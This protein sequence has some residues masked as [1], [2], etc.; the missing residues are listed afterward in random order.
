[1]KI[2]N[3]EQLNQQD[4]EQAGSDSGLSRRK[5][6][7]MIGAA[8]AAAAAG[9]LLS[10]TVG[11]AQGN[12]VTNSVYGPPL[13]LGPEWC[14]RKT[15]IAE[16]RAMTATVAEGIYYV[17]DSGK[18]G[19]FH[20]DASDTSSADNTGT[21]LVSASGLRFKR[22]YNGA[23]DALWFGAKGDGSTDDTAAIRLAIAAMQNGDSL[24]FPAGEYIVDSGCL[25]FRGLSNITI[26]G[27]GVNSWLHPSGQRTPTSKTSFHT[28]MAIDQCVSLTIRDLRIESKGENWG[29]TDAGTGAGWGDGRTNF[30]IEKG[31]HAL[32]VTRSGNVVVENIVGRLCG[33]V[34]VFY[35]SSCDD[36]VVRDC[37][38]NAS[39]LGYAMYAVDNW[40][41]PAQQMRR[42]YNF[43]NCNGWNEPGYSPYS[44]KA[45]ILVE[46]DPGMILN[47]NVQGG[48]FKNCTIGGDYKILGCAVGAV[49]ANANVNGVTSDSCLIGYLAGARGTNAENM[50]HTV[51]GCSFM[52]NR[53]T[54]VMLDFKAGTGDS[55][56]YLKDTVIRTKE[57]S[58]WSGYNDLR[59]KY[60]SGI[61]NL[62][63]LKGTVHLS[64]VSMAGGEYGM[65]MMDYLDLN[66]QSSEVSGSKSALTVYGGGN[67]ELYGTNVSSDL[68]H[69]LVFRTANITQ[70]GTSMA[71]R[72]LRMAAAYG[73]LNCGVDQNLF[74]IIG[75]AGHT[76]SVVVK[77]NVV[78]NGYI[79]LV[80]IYADTKTFDEMLSYTTA[81]VTAVNFAG[82]NTSV[83][84]ALPKDKHYQ[85]TKIINE[86]G[87]VSPIP[88]SYNDFGSRG[89][90]RII[91]QGDVRASFPVGAV[92]RLLA[93]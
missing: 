81:I 31:G 60:S 66:S 7:A 69:A 71:D 62:S 33:S 80:G 35:F 23:L 37:F 43:I 20:A 30:A 54:G 1:M 74:S 65:Y 49:Y 39:S 85:Y 22:I 57:T 26:C 93:L 28:T 59:V 67:Y 4:T 72:E 6:L 8:G 45:G 76:K 47:V 51:T 48:I 36:V 46:G 5:L 16:L 41:A 11:F 61:S 44:A 64:N 14:V 50:M 86:A 12:G 40:C 70:M 91:L 24:Y 3:E 56:L 18:G 83:H 19:H 25:L 13:G 90:Y 53:V 87:A 88:V 52:N 27:D 34:G 10:G 79:G 89:V 21:I 92:C 9:P 82:T 17:T 68:E 15:T 2:V 32:L 77:D 84:F 63:Y 42:T 38:S 73:I 29:N 58:H 78:K 75:T 55:Q